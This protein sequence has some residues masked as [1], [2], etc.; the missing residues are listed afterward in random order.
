MQIMH[1]MQFPPNQ[2]VAMD[3]KQHKP[4]AHMCTYILGKALKS[5]AFFCAF[6]K[7]AA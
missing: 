6:M 5:I 3:G 2:V 4:D 1:I 7:P